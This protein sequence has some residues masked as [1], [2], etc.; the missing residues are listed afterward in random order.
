MGPEEVAI[1]AIQS[2]A[3]SADAAIISAIAACLAAV[4]GPLIAF[5]IARHQLRASTVLVSRQQ[6]MNDFRT[7]L[8]KFVGAVSFLILGLEEENNSLNPDKLEERMDAALE[9][10]SRIELRLNPAEELHA[11]LLRDL[12]SF[13]LLLSDAGG[14]GVGVRAMALND[15]IMSTS[16]KILRSEWERIIKGEGV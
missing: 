14:T 11:D 8:S 3:R 16:R 2:A 12:D 10:K 7:E 9:M 6:W 5:L 4:A 15:S 1:Q 13:A